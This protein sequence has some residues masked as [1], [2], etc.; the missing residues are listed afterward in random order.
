MGAFRDRGSW[1]APERHNSNELPQAGPKRTQRHFVCA[2][3]IW[4][5]ALVSPQAG[6]R[7]TPAHW[8]AARGGPPPPF[9]PRAARVHALPPASHPRQS[10]PW[11]VGNLRVETRQRPFACW[12]HRWAWISPQA[13]RLGA[14][15][16]RRERERWQPET[17]WSLQRPH[18]T[19]LR[20]VPTRLGCSREFA[21]RFADLMA[22]YRYG[23]A[24]AWGQRG[25]AQSLGSAGFCNK[26][27]RLKHPLP[28]HSRR[29]PSPAQKKM[30][31]LW[32]RMPRKSWG[33]QCLAQPRLERRNAKLSGCCN[34]MRRLLHSRRSRRKCNNNHNNK[35]SLR[36]RRLPAPRHPFWRQRSQRRTS[37]APL[38][39]SSS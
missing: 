38:L 37:A 34:R 28:K 5:Q 7:L 4:A 27:P 20:E 12:P 17:G 36:G 23:S 39:R 15:S 30:S 13:P 14:K 24:K 10:A 16:R 11:A 33:G 22:C 6:W 9:C 29:L 8:C 18:K 3:A 35:Q 21:T 19:Q 2:V 25:G 31:N 1:R 26:R 32:F